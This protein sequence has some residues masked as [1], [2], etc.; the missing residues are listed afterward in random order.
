M[1]IRRINGR[2]SLNNH[3]VALNMCQVCRPRSSVGCST[4]PACFASTRHW[5][6][7]CFPWNSFHGPSL[8]VSSWSLEVEQRS[9]VGRGDEKG[10]S[11]LWTLGRDVVRERAAVC[12]LLG[13]HGTS[14]KFKQIGHH[15]FQA[16]IVVVLHK[17][18]S[19]LGEVH[20][21][22]ATKPLTPLNI[23]I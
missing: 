14:E 13:R 1:F 5:R 3:L 11:K 7:L 16:G 19:Y 22:L 10:N 12:S 8:T 21:D 18:C 9:R 23:N 15:S 17:H 6:P 2:P 20:A 4:R